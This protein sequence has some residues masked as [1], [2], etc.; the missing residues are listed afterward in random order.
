MW[1][2]AGSWLLHSTKEELTCMMFEKLEMSRSYCIHPCIRWCV[3]WLLIRRV[4][5]EVGVSH[6]CSLIF[7]PTK[8][9]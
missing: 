7:D 4:C 9:V 3:L 1:I 5:G 6:F 2:M 8:G